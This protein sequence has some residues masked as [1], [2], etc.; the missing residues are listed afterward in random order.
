MISRLQKLGVT[1]QAIEQPL[2]LS[3]PENMLTLAVYL[4]MPQVENER[5]ALNV[6]HGMRRAKKEGRYMGCAPVGYANKTD[7]TGRKYIGLKEPQATLMRWV[8]H[9]L[10]E[11]TFNT[12]QVYKTARE[13]GFTGAKSLFW[14]AI[15]NPVYCG[16]ISIPKHKDES[17][18]F[19]KGQHEPLISEALFYEVQAVLDGR[20]R[21]QYKPKITSNAALPLR[22]FLLCPQCGKILSGSSSRGRSK[23]YTYY[24]CFDGCTCRFSAETV[25]TTFSNELKKYQPRLV[26]SELYRDVILESWHQQAPEVQDNTRQL[27]N[28]IKELDVKL[29]NIRN[30]VALEKITPEDFHEMKAQFTKRQETLERQLLARR[31]TVD[32]KD[33]LNKGIYNLIHLYTLYQDSEID[34]KRE[35]IGSIF[36]EKLTFDGT[37]V[38]TTYINE[39]V[40]HIYLCDSTL[41]GNKNG[42]NQQNANLSRQVGAAG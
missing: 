35:I 5:R 7:E 38:R 2:D 37:A 26:Y 32:V 30:Q 11:G 13:K 42:T 15:R 1:T 9:K 31:E 17:A 23:Y 6:I 36:P 12:E 40:R 39:A 41:G 29:S 34:T 18:R 16:L 19:V 24:H 14:T 33:L 21:S 4:A 10:A 3:V 8:F 25:N 27:R 22:G 28:E 20:K